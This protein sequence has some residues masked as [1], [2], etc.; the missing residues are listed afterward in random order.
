VC[1]LS[2][3]AGA[4][5]FMG[6]LGRVQPAIQHRGRAGFAFRYPGLQKLTGK[7]TNVSERISIIFKTTNQDVVLG[8][9]IGIAALLQKNE[10]IEEYLIVGGLLVAEK[11]T[12]H[13][14]QCLFFNFSQ[15]SI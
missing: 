8:R 11:R 3:F 2:W 9:Q 4:H 15:N 14:G 7:G 12:P 1:P 13:S 10:L 6:I 5:E